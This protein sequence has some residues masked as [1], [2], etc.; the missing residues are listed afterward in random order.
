MF[1]SFSATLKWTIPKTD[2]C[3]W[4]QTS[5]YA[6]NVVDIFACQRICEEYASCLSVDY[7]TSTKKCLFNNVDTSMVQSKTCS[8]YQFSEPF[9]GTV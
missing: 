6:E 9:K 1:L 3:I 4:G 2:I 5:G 8:N 7:Q